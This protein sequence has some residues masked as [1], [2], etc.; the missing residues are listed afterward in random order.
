MTRYYFEISHSGISCPDEEGED[1]PNV[2][3]ALDAARRL[4]SELAL[5]L[6]ELRGLSITVSD[7]QCGT[8]GNILVS[9]PKAALQ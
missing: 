9:V 7:E 2:K 3:A 1:F 4:G 6:P 8:V 5:E